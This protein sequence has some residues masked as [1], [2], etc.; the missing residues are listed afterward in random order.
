MLWTAIALVIGAVVIGG[1][2]LLTSKPS[3]GTALGSPIAPHVTTPANVPS[4]GL[5]LG[6]ADAKVTI[7][8]WED[9]RCTACFAFTTEIEPTVVT[10]LVA[11]GKAKIVYHDLIVIDGQPGHEDE[12]ESRDAA[13]AARCANDQVK[14]WPVHDWLFANQSP[15]ELAGSFTID[16]LV[17]IGSA[18]GLDMSIYEPCVRNGTHNA[19]VLAEQGAAPAD[20][21]STP[22]I[23][24]GG[25]IVVNSQNS[26]LIPTADDV[27]AAV[28]AVL[29]PASPSPSASAAASASPT[30]APT[31]SPS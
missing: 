15:R 25:K 7:D 16:R 6:S 30:A 18:A 3:N 24:V 19:E 21:T 1:A 14:F 10:D 8:V 4:S 2:Y 9:Y 11:T 27:A 29:N 13:N 22:S 23:Y 31:A 5:T 12:T 28:N 17:A 20:A 26:Q